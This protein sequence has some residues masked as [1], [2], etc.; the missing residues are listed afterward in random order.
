MQVFIAMKVP[1]GTAG[2]PGEVDPVQLVGVVA[3]A[4]RRAGHT[5]FVAYQEIAQRGL[6]PK[7]FMPFVRQHIQQSGLVIVLYDPELRGGL[8]EEGIAY[9]AGVPIWLLHRRG[10]RVS[11]TA[12]ACAERV[13]E[14]ENSDNIR[15]FD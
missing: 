2:H 4:V 6:K 12:L 8:V 14:Y 5:P 13:I 1:R 11:T 15:L 9:A 3:E 7:V 10:Q